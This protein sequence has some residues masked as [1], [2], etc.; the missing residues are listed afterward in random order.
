MPRN[1][2]NIKIE[3]KSAVKK[4]WYEFTSKELGSPYLES[5]DDIEEN[6]K[7][8]IE[9]PYDSVVSIGYEFHCALESI[10]EKYKLCEDV[11]YVKIKVEP[12]SASSFARSE[13]LNYK[14]KDERFIKE[15]EIL[16]E[17]RTYL[18]NCWAYYIKK[19]GENFYNNAL[20]KATNG[21]FEASFKF[22]PNNNKM[23]IVIQ[24]IVEFYVRNGYKMPEDQETFKAVY[25]VASEDY[26]TVNL[27][28]KEEAA[29][30]MIELSDLIEIID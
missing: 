9:F 5:K 16:L 13:R 3:K 1:P 23:H 17:R 11:N 27:K 15:A 24:N 21:K 14:F 2:S 29:Q 4:L 25:L 19:D 12:V 18:A 22:V 10:I 20:Q 26:Y 30:L 28:T 8:A 6:D 7:L